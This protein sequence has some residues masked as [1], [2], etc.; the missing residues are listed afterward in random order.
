SRK[1]SARDLAAPLR[2]PPDGV[3]R[4]IRKAAT[5]FAWPFGQRVASSAKFAHA[6]IFGRRSRSE[7]S[8]RRIAWYFC[9]TCMECEAG[10]V[11]PDFRREGLIKGQRTSTRLLI[12]LF[13]AFRR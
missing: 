12:R 5:R 6:E 3:S 9:A 10:R 7:R 8:F 13:V 2:S 4:K 11:Q 1:V